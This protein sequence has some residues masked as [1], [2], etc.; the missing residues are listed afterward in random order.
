LTLKVVGPNSHVERL[1]VIPIEELGIVGEPNVLVSQLHRQQEESGPQLES[2]PMKQRQKVITQE[3]HLLIWLKT[4]DAILNYARTNNLH[5]MWNGGIIDTRD[6][7][8]LVNV[9][10]I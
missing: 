3:Q 10:S 8:D 5:G 4:K 7:R 1:I 6:G 2:E 9:V